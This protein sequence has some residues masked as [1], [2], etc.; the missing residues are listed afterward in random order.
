MQLDATTRQRVQTCFD[1][2]GLMQTLGAKLEKVDLGEV[3]LTCDLQEGLTQQNGFFHAGVLS[4]LLDAAC[5]FA[6]LTQM[7]VDKN[8]LSVEFKM[9]LMKPVTLPHIKVFGKVLQAGRTLVICEGWVTDEAEAKVYTKMMATMIA[10][11]R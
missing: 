11:G 1:Q 9:N 3:I 7:P 5:G 4:S 8:V 10:A 6:A 2:Q